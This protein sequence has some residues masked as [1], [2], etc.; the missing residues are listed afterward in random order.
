MI[1]NRHKLSTDAYQSAQGVSLSDLQA[2]QQRSDIGVSD[3]TFVLDIS[4]ENRRQ[5]MQRGGVALDRFEG[6]FD[7]QERVARNYRLLAQTAADDKREYYGLVHVIDANGTP[8]EVHA[9][10]TGVLHPF[11]AVWA[12]LVHSS[13]HSVARTQ[14]SPSSNPAA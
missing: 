12:E 5:R 14:P 7:F 2:L 3:V 9:Y 4:S 1:S 6:D 11:Y 8:D 13:A 10:L